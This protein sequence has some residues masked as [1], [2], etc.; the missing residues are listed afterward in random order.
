M[1]GL[2]VK[3]LRLGFRVGSLGLGL[4]FGFGNVG[5]NVEFRARVQGSG[6]RD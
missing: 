4:G 6:F 3:G 1:G 5:S 2:E